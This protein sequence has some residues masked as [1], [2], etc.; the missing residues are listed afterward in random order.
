MN[1]KDLEAAMTAFKGKIQVVEYGERSE[2]ALVDDILRYCKC[3]CKG[4]YTDHSI[5][6]GEG[7]FADQ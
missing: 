4:C 6:Q 5:R 2:A 3:G 7:R 1:S